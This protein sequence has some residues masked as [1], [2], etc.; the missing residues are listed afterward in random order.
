MK[1][2]NK[3]LLILSIFIYSSIKAQDSCNWGYLQTP[4]K[5][6]PFAVNSN[7]TQLLPYSPAEGAE[8]FYLR[9]AAAY[10]A[11]GDSCSYTYLENAAKS[12][13][14]AI[15]SGCSQL[16]QY[17]PAEGAI[18]YYLRLLAQ[19]GGGGGKSY[20]KDSAW[21]LTGN[22]GTNITSNFIGTLDH[23]A[24]D[25]RINNIPSGYIGFTNLYFGYKAPLAS[26]T[27]GNTFLGAYTGASGA[28]PPNYS[29]ALGFAARITASN[30]VMIG[31][32]SSIG[33]AT[34]EVAFYGALSPN[35]ASN[36]GTSGQ[37]LNSNG[38]STAP[39]WTS[40]LAN[41]IRASTQLPYNRSTL[42]ATTRYA[43]Y[44]ASNVMKYYNAMGWT[45]KGGCPLFTQGN[46]TTTFTLGS[47][48]LVL[49][50]IWVD[51][52]CTI[53]GINWVLTQAGAYTNVSGYNGFGLCKISGSNYSLVDSTTN[54]TQLFTATASTWQSTPFASTYQ[55]TP[56]LYILYVLYQETAQVTAP[57]MAAY[58]T[59]INSGAFY[60]P[61]LTANYTFFGYQT[62]QT[63]LPQTR[64]ISAFTKGVFPLALYLY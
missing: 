7:C 10:M 43:D 35:G 37:I 34:S 52:T 53:T 58:T 18:V 49:E 54:N 16:V 25:F 20:V 13:P 9:E 30:Q 8:I 46:I 29:T 15:N 23:T 21:L 1:G 62:S 40:T 56:G 48:T 3:F 2:M 60:S 55:A 38:A 64:A 28:S 41:G 45:V 19:G 14:F 24:L 11:G 32:D 63:I 33:T 44:V 57:I 26:V 4:A 39:A 31:N 27:I 17:T 6:F 47:G 12:F 50:A 51:D 36:D 5:S 59:P 22:S 42:L 61:P